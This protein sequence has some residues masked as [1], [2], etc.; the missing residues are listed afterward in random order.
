MDSGRRKFG[1]IM[2]DDVEIG[3]GAKLMPG[4]KIGT[5]AWIG[6][7]TTVYEDVPPETF[8]MQKQEIIHGHR[9]RL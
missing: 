9:K 4:V 6:P 3:I 1:V 7:N 5:S 2:G 8:V